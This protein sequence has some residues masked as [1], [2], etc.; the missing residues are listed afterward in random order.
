MNLIIPLLNRD[1]GDQLRFALRS[2]TTHMP[3]TRCILVGGKPAWYTGEHISHPDYIPER[4]E[5]NIRDKT[6]AG[7]T[8]VGEFLYANDDFILMA[9]LST[10][11]NKGTLSET[12]ATRNKNGS[13]GRLLQNTIARYGDV[14]NVDTHCPMMMTE[15]GVKR[16]AFDWPIFG[17]GFKTCYAQENGIISEY[18]P[19]AKITSGMRSLWFSLHPSYRVRELFGLFPDKCTFER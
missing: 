8:G 18:M 5:E 10:T 13:Y 16:T 2:I 9:P 3:I 7:S 17:Y 12:L 4:K 1:R 11:W 19:D 15:E 14:P 6:I